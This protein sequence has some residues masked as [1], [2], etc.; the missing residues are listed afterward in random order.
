MVLLGYFDTVPCHIGLSAHA[1]TQPRPCS[2]A[3]QNA[4]FFK[5]LRHI[6]SLDVCMKH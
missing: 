5:I 1:C 4:K 2:V 3:P 6:E